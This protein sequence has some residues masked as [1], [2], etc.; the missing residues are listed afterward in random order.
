M[1]SRT[2]SGPQKAAQKEAEGV[3]SPTSAAD[4]QEEEQAIGNTLKNMEAKTA[5][6]EELEAETPVDCE[7]GAWGRYSRCS[8][9]CG[10]GEK[11]D[12]VVI[13]PPGV[14]MD[15]EKYELEQ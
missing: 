7:M 4:V 11:T 2:I 6:K 8:K 12:T 3:A 15:P 5:V 1:I 13:K 9:S 14:D 10:G